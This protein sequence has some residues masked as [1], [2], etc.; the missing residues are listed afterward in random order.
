[1]SFN[2]IKQPSLHIDIIFR[3]KL[4]FEEIKALK[5]KNDFQCQN[6]AHG[7]SSEVLKQ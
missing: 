4:Y 6:N 2:C 7:Y 5:H 3:N 1:M